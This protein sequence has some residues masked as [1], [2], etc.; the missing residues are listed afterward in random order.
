LIIGTG[1]A[2]LCMAIRL[3]MAGMESFVV[4]ERAAELGG[5]WRDN[6]YPGCACDVES[7]LYSYSFESNAGWSR[8]YAGQSEILEYLHGCA[9]KYGLLSH[10]RFGQNV[11]RARFDEQRRVW[12]V[13]TEGGARYHARVVV[14][15]MGALSNPAYPDL[16]GAAR[17]QGE[18]FHSATWN[19]G[20]DLGGKKV[21]VVGSGASAIQ[22]VPEIAPKVAR[23]DLYQ[24]TP[25]WI[26]PKPDRPI[27]GAERAVYR[28]LPLAQK[29]MRLS[30][31]CL[32]EMRVLAFALDPALMRYAARYARHHLRR[33]VADPELRKKL[34]PAYTMGCKR[35]LISNDYYGALARPNVELVTDG[36]REIR[37]HSIVDGAGNEREVDALIFAT[38][39]QVQ[40]P[41]PKG[42][43]SG[44]GGL[45]LGEQWSAGAEAYKG[46]SV[47]GF[48]NLFLL[49]GP[50][51]GLG[52]SSMIYMIESQ[53]AY[54]IDALRQMR[55]RGWHVLEVEPEAQAAFNRAVQA[56]SARAVWKTGC[57]SWYLN[58]DGRNTTLWP[59]FT[60]RFRQLTRRFDAA[61]YRVEAAAVAHAP[62]PASVAGA[63][64][65][66]NSLEATERA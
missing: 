43:I 31:Y 1:F 55:K 53:V 47:A 64:A 65:A 7:H 54:I 27:R 12:V 28:A 23:L 62:A 24:R 22:F 50:N 19:H 51:T 6:H 40:A 57:M 5:T 45:D 8:R 52:H 16:D 60:F 42:M 49:L 15:G 2:G 14:S 20:Y 33:S 56:R 39:F 48:P 18:R 63:G 30:V 29:L 13:E 66:R 17:F 35:V 11:T 44:R 41:V 61:A 46:T 38:G 25:P 59:G 32:L 36:I 4:L 34:T 37:A 58:Q 26:V 9:R 3:R 21:A 10:I